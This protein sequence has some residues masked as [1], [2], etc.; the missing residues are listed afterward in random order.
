MKRK[1]G[2][3][4]N[5]TSYILIMPGTGKQSVIGELPAEQGEIIPYPNVDR[6]ASYQL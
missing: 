3:A 5:K 2:S 1:L 4:E 6:N